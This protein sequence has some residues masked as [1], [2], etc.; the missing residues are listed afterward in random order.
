[1][2]ADSRWILLAQAK[3][4]A[5][6]PGE[7]Y[8][9]Y[10]GFKVGAAVVSAATGRF[11]A[12]A[13]SRI[14]VS[15]QRSARNECHTQCDRRGRSHWGRS[16]GSRIGRCPPAPPCAQCLQVLAEFS[17]AETEIH[18]VIWP[19]AMTYTDST[20]CSLIRSSFLRSVEVLYV[21]CPDIDIC[22]KRRLPVLSQ[23]VFRLPSSP[24]AWGVRLPLRWYPARR[25]TIP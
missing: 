2:K 12:V 13:T 22:T 20:R 9:P 24:W 8:A 15:V 19:D 1:M 21:S 10:S 5:K 4:A 6:K 16:A 14:P 17:R 11:I 7:R 18:L 23:Y 25:S 3:E